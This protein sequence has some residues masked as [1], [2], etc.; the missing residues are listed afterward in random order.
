MPIKRSVYDQVH[1]PILIT[2]PPEAIQ[3]HGLKGSQRWCIKILK[4]HSV[5][6]SEFNVTRFQRTESTLG[7]PLPTRQK[8]LDK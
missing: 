5:R 2:V 8:T 3:Q 1:S 4:G 7:M 6:K